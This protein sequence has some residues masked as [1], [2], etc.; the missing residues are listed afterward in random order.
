M[1]EDMGQNIWTVGGVTESLLA[2]EVRDLYPAICLFKNFNNLLLRVLA[3]L[4]LGQQ[5]A[6]RFATKKTL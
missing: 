3:L 1:A 5:R 2:A 4:E 6:G